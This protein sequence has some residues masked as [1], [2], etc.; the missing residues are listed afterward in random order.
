MVLTKDINV[1][2]S[3]RQI[4]YSNHQFS[5]KQKQFLFK[6]SIPVFQFSND[7][8]SFQLFLLTILKSKN[9]RFVPIELID[10]L[11]GLTTCGVIL[12]SIIKLL[13]YTSTTDSSTKSYCNNADCSGV[14]RNG[15]L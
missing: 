8:F 14:A 10:T 2:I 7:I 12:D 1:M 9:S 3:F 15:I 6:Y 5:L 13:F 4:K 11:S